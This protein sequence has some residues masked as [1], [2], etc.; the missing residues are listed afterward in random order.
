MTIPYAVVLRGT[1]STLLARL[2]CLSHELRAQH[3]TP[4]ITKHSSVDSHTS[5]SRGLRLDDA[6]GMSPSIVGDA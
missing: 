2:S 4:F 3:S 6:A 1:G 5:S